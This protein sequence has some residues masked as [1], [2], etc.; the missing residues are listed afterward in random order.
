MVSIMS[1]RIGDMRYTALLVFKSG[2]FGQNRTTPN[3][4][5]YVFHNKD[6][7]CGRPH[8]RKKLPGHGFA[9]NELHEQEAR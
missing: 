3:K 4:V 1:W 8:K 7:E 9:G 6:R 5:C 2:P